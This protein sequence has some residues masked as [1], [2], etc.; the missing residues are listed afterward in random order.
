MQG[1]VM[2]CYSEREQGYHKKY[3]PHEYRCKS[4]TKPQQV[5]FKIH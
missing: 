3:I 2:K 4:F 1:H 5:E